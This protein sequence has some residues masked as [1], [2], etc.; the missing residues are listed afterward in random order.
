MRLTY[1]LTTLVLLLSFSSCDRG[2]NKLIVGSIKGP[3]EIAENS[4]TEYKI[5]AHSDTGITY[6]WISN[7]VGTGT[8]SST[9]TESVI[10]TA[11]EVETDYPIVIRVVVNSDNDGPVIRSLDVIVKNVP[12]D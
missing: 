11:P 6:S 12:D 8:F 7:P 2:N 3:T 4:S 9:D 10:F 5:D 1:Y